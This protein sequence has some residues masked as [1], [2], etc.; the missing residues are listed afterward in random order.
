MIDVASA[1]GRCGRSRGGAVGGVAS[2]LPSPGGEFGEAAVRPAVDELAK[3]VGEVSL[4][5]DA[6]QL[7]GFDQRGENG[8]VFGTQ[9]VTGKQ[10][11]LAIEGN[12]PDR[13]LDGIG[14]DLDPA[15]IEEADQRAPVVERVADGLGERRLPR[16]LGETLLEPELRSTVR[17]GL[18]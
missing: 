2:C 7:A 16:Q 5:V 13:T 1:S 9:I 12:R 18:R 15:V 8:P 4:G 17:H 6:V 14:V 10:R 11:I 3:H